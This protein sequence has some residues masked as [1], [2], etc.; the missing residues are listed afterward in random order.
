M[1]AILSSRVFFGLRGQDFIEKITTETRVTEFQL[2]ILLSAYAI[3]RTVRSTIES[4]RSL[5]FKHCCHLVRCHVATQGALLS[6]PPLLRLTR[7]LPD[8]MQINCICF[9]CARVNGQT[10]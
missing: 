8:S 1:K 5:W 9:G 4:A 2:M 7:F 6:R 3:S 10:W